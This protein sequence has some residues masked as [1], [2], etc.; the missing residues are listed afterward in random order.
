MDSL[1]K[2]IF[3]DLQ[4]SNC[5]INFIGEKFLLN[6]LVSIFINFSCLQGISYIVVRVTWIVG[7][8]NVLETPVI[9]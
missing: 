5:T 7:L 6:A 4:F 2:E 3:R 1:K 9:T 8:D